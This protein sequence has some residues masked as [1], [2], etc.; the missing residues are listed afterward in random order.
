MSRVLFVVNPIS[1]NIDKAGIISSMEDYCGQCGLE[2]EILMT[3]GEGDRGRIAGKVMDWRPDLAVACGGDGTVNLLGSVLL[4]SEVEVVMAILPLGSSNGLATDLEIPSD[5]RLAM[6]LLQGGRDLEIDVMQINDEQYSFHLA[7][8]GFN[9]KLIQ[10]FESE[11]ERGVMAYARHFFRNIS[12]KPRVS[13]RFQFPD[14]EMKT[15]AS[16]ITFANAQRFGTGAVVNPMG[17]LDDGKFEVCIFQPWPDWYMPWMT[18]L[19]FLG[20]LNESDYVRIVSTRQVEVSGN[21]DQPLQIDGEVMGEVR[22][23]RVRI[24]ESKLRVRV[25]E[26]AT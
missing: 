16:M 11:E 26:P 18:L 14:Q 8:L 12:Y 24:H 23:V 5:P 19:F 7:G 10:D 17:S 6:E 9:A 15:K 21:E 20:R 4:K 2:W 13:Y 25:P 1:G 22:E 3:E